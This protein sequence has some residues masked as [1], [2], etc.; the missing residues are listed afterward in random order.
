MAWTGS[1]HCTTTSERR[2]LSLDALPK[3]WLMLLSVMM[4]ALFLSLPP[5]RAQ[6][7]PTAMS[8]GCSTL[9]WNAVAQIPDAFAATVGDRGR[10]P[11]GYRGARAVVQGP[12]SEISPRA[13]ADA[14]RRHPPYS[15]WT[16]LPCSTLSPSSP[17]CASPGCSRRI[18]SRR[19][20]R[21]NARGCGV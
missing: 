11:G 18:D 17:R 19:C 14:T 2:R 7:T 4:L 16:I 5:S 13:T 20:Q 10:E 6:V 21:S 1:T 15:N 3:G 9:N 12:S 8:Y